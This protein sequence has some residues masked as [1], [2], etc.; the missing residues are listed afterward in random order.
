VRLGQVVSVLRFV[1]CLL[2]PETI[3]DNRVKI[4]LL[5]ESYNPSENTMTINLDNK[6]ISLSWGVGRKHLNSLPIDTELLRELKDNCFFDDLLSML[7]NEK[8]TELEENILTA[9]YW[10]GE[11][12]NDFVYESAFI[13]CWTALETIFSIETKEIEES[14]GR[15]VSILLAFGGYR[16]IKID[17]IEEVYKKVIKLYDKRCKVIHRGVYEIVSPLELLEL[18]KYAVWSI[19]TCLELRNKGYE[20]LEQI[21]IEA[22]RLYEASR[23]H[24]RGRNRR[25]RT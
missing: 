1:V 10:I 5:S 17:E 20:K 22:N 15:G 9:V 21:R 8:R 13:K 25:T 4:N 7:K 12:Q 2:R 24:L 6:G 23:S 3:Y 19:L 11:A 16:F 14:L 18:C